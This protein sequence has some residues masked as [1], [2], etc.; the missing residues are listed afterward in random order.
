MS[1]V[2]ANCL[3]STVL[4]STTMGATITR[5]ESFE[6]IAPPDSFLTLVDHD[7][8]RGFSLSG[9]RFVVVD[10]G[11]VSP[12]TNGSPS[13]YLIH[14]YAFE[15]GFE[16]NF[17]H[18]I[19]SFSARVAVLTRSSPDPGDVI[20]VQWFRE[21]LQL[22][23]RLETVSGLGAF[24]STISDVGLAAATRLRIELVN[25]DLQSIAIDDLR[26]TLIPEPSSL[27]MTLFASVLVGYR[28]RTASVKCEPG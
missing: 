20:R 9:R 5:E 19:Q 1:T 23:D 16:I 24:D 21:D 17:S 22:S 11:F 27:A 3:V 15:D 4:A 28:W 2:V 26:F 7:R 18:P 25:N 12:N 13:A 6:S 14:D 8:F 10:G